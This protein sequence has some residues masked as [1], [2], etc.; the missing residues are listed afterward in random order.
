MGKGRT[1]DKDG[2]KDD[3]K[4]DKNTDK[5]KKCKCKTGTMFSHLKRFKLKTDTVAGQ[6]DHYTNIK[7]TLRRMKTEMNAN[8]RADQLRMD[9]LIDSMITIG[10][11]F[12]LLKQE[13]SALRDLLRASGTAVP[14]DVGSHDQTRSLRDVHYMLASIADQVAAM[15]ES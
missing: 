11:E 5:P 2:K 7:A 6:R 8:Q 10:R 15:R 14:E 13:V 1:G 4:D 3:Y 9:T 12:F